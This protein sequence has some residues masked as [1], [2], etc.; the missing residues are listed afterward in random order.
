[1]PDAPVSDVSQQGMNQPDFTSPTSLARLQARKAGSRADH[2]DAWRV[3]AMRKPAGVEGDPLRV[4]PSGP[5]DY[6]L[7]AIQ[8]W[9]FRR[10]GLFPERAMQ[11][12][13]GDFGA[14]AVHPALV[15]DPFRP[16]AVPGGVRRCRVRAKPL[17]PCETSRLSISKKL[18]KRA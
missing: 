10:E 5:F 1:M 14:R 2:G 6:S 3:L 11:K 13:R 16:P 8:T 9:G 4:R 18:A 15:I 7:S 12:R 17:Y